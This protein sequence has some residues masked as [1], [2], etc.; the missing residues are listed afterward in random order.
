MPPPAAVFISNR[1]E[2]AT[3]GMRRMK[4]RQLQQQSL[5]PRVIDLNAHKETAGHVVLLDQHQP[6]PNKPYFESAWPR[7]VS[8]ILGQSV[9]LKCRTR[10]LGDRMV[11]HPSL[12]NFIRH[13]WA[14]VL[15][16]QSGP[17]LIGRCLFLFSFCLVVFFCKKLSN[18]Q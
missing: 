6:V 13:C 4:R 15:A 12:G 7:N 3:S 14:E 5:E 18:I 10:L 1:P 11:C 9:A 16:G 2:S 8:V 17:S